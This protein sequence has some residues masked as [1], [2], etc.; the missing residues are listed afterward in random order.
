MFAAQARLSG[1][2]GLGR[3]ISNPGLNESKTFRMNRGAADLRHHDF[4][5]GG[6]QTVNEDGI[7]RVARHDVI[8]PAVHVAG[9]IGVFAK[10]RMQGIKVIQPE[11]D[12]SVARR[13]ARLMAVGAVVV[14][15]SERTIFEPA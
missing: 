9:G 10:A 2:A 14:E 4:G 13:T 5:S 3:Q 6:S 8:L 11:I 12:A 15:I 1:S 7:L